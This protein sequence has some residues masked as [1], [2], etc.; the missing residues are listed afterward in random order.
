MFPCMPCRGRRQ[1]R[2]ALCFL[3]ATVSA[4]VASAPSPAVATGP[5]LTL[6]AALQQAL[7]SDPWLEGSRHTERA[8]RD[9][10]EAAAALS[11]PSISLRAGNFPL[12]TFDIN[13]EPMTQSSVALT[14]RFPRGATR[15]LAQRQK[16]QLAG[17]HPLLRLDRRAQVT[18]TVSALWLRVYEAEQSMRII[19]AQRGLLEQ[20]LVSAQ[21]RY[22]TALG[23]SGQ[24]AVLAAEL[25][26]LRL[27]DR[28]AQLA[29]RRDTA[30]QELAEWVG[31]LAALPPSAELPEPALLRPLPEAVVSAVVPPKDDTRA[32]AYQWIHQH[33]ALLALEQRIEASHTDVD[34]A[35][36]QYKPGWGLTAQYGYRARDLAGEDRAD[37]LSLGLNLEL[38]LFNSDRNDRLLGAARSRYQALRTE[39]LLLARRMLAEL[40][41]ARTTLTRL[42]ERAALYR[43]RLLPHLAEQAETALAAYHSGEGDFSNT[44]DTRIAE[45]DARIE[46]LG[47]AVQRATLVARINYLL[48]E[49]PANAAGEVAVRAGGAP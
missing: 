49:V 8:L 9:E 33:P 21:A 43:N 25:A 42:Q 47:I 28:L 38:P 13:Q 30:Q 44:L 1:S 3:L 46:A 18:A 20:A 32:R 16:Q 23:S 17:E 15:R 27:Q 6:A 4:A 14:Q 48:T 41:T 10:S 22:A 40:D 7:S 29:Q 34:L 12:D 11:D 39:K 35:R 37:L 31:S 36:Q 26:L 45:M 5:T 19:D 24:E 2:A